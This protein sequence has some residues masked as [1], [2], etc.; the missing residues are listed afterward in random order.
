MILP[1]IVA[2]AALGAQGFD[3]D[4][5]LVADTAQALRQSGFV[6]AIRYLS[7][8][9]GQQA[10]DLSASEAQ[11][12]L[13]AGLALM[14][15]QHCPRPGWAPAAALGENYGQAAAL[16][17]AAIGLPQ[18]V[19]LWLDLEDV[20]PYATAA[21]TISYCNAWAAAAESHDFGAG[22]YVGANQPLSGDELYWRLRVTR[23]WRSA[24][25]VPEIPYRGYCMAQALAPSPVAEIDIDRDVV[26]ADAFGGLPMW[27]APAT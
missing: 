22:L 19:T 17:A 4:T 9:I 3:S 18:G 27:L 13:A 16:N 21:D 15:V 1:G 7:R 24:S 14:T 5:M 10:G 8:A 20:A 6:F 12:I 25:Q 26:M 11:T 2:A 23:Y